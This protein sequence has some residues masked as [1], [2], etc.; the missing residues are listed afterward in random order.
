MFWKIANNV[1]ALIGDSCNVNHF[2]SSR[3]GIPFNGCASQRFQTFRKRDHSG[4]EG[5]NFPN[6]VAHNK[7][8]NATHPRKKYKDRRSQNRQEVARSVEF[9]VPDG[10]ETFAAPEDCAKHGYG[11]YWWDFSKGRLGARSEKSQK[12]LG[13][14]DKFTTKLQP[15]NALIRT[16]WTYLDAVLENYSYWSHFLNAVAR[17][18]R[19]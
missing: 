12:N 3:M 1:V 17:I 9:H 7:S 2:I 6:P 8:G 18:V 13:E 11:G 15:K 16:P 4:D 14:L 5:N 10:A 19:N